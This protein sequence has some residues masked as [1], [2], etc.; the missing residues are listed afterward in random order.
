MEP[1]VQSIDTVQAGVLA[2]YFRILGNGGASLGP[3]LGRLNLPSEVAHNPSMM[4]PRELIHSLAGQAAISTGVIEL[5]A[6]AGK[7]LKLDELGPLG[8]GIQSGVTLYDAGKAACDVISKTASAGKCWIELRFGY[9]WFCYRDEVQFGEGSC[10]AETY[11][12]MM[13]TQFV[14]LAA[15][16]DW[17]PERIRV[18]ESSPKIIRQIEE[19]SAVEI[20]NDK[21]T[22]AVAFPANWIGKEIKRPFDSDSDSDS[23]QKSSPDNTHPASNTE[24]V[25]NLLQSILPCS[26]LPDLSTAAEMLSIHPRA[27]QRTLA[28]EDTRYR[29]L[30][31]LAR[32]HY[33]AKTLK[34][35]PKIK[36]EELAFLL[37][38][39]GVNNFTRAFKRIAGVAPGIFR[40]VNLA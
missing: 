4:I 33:A 19:F 22:T 30:V 40:K 27:L 25:Q 26:R 18:C 31:E 28:S 3:I 15:N 13:L 8:S 2:P 11:K 5:G 39:S 12:L 36:L 37:G 38:Y 35:E 1:S 20:I 14:R 17:Y 34:Q 6:N 23:D 24:A 32:Y 21:N 16:L 10:Q 7:E 9:A 29:D